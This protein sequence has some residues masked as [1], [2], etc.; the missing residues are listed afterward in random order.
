MKNVFTPEPWRKKEPEHDP[1][2]EEGK[3]FERQINQNIK[4]LFVNLSVG[5]QKT[6]RNFWVSLQ[7]ELS[8]E[9]IQAR[10]E[11]GFGDLK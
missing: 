3:K 9:E 1:N 10:I 6:A 2:Q 5:K 7:N 11:K 8:I 4:I